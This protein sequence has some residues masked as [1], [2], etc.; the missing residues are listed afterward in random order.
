MIVPDMRNAIY[1]MHLAGMSQRQIS[2]QFGISRHTVGQIIRQQGVQVPKV[3]SNKIRVETELLQ[4]LYGECDGWPRGSPC[5][6]PGAPI[7]GWPGQRLELQVEH[8]AGRKHLP[9]VT[10][11]R[12]A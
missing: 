11:R 9:V 2:R 1:Q 4:R 12:A 3:R 8:V 5:A 10:I 6:R 7:R